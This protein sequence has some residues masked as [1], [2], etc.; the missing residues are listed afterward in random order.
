MILVRKVTP[1]TFTASWGRV[2]YGQAVMAPDDTLTRYPGHFEAAFATFEE[3][4]VPRPSPAFDHTARHALDSRAVPTEEQIIAGK[5]AVARQEH[6]Q[7]DEPIGE[8]ARAAL[9]DIDED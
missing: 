9:L 2:K 7:F 5:A 3:Y 1:G 8:T 4:G 6:G